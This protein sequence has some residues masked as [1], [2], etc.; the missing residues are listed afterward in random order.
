MRG[1]TG[2][3]RAFDFVF[4]VKAPSE[5][6]DL[7]DHLLADLSVDSAT[8]ADGRPAV[9]SIDVTRR[10]SGW[11]TRCTPDPPRRGELGD[12]IADVIQVINQRGV[13]SSP[14][15]VALHAAAIATDRGIVALMGSS[16]AGKS[17]LAAGAVLTGMGYVADEVTVI[18]SDGTAQPFHRP[19]GLRSGGALALGIDTPVHADGRFDRVYPWRPARASLAD[20]GPLVAV[21]IVDHVDG[22][23]GAWAPL[24]PA[25]A[26]IEMAAGAFGGDPDNDR[27][28]FHQ[29]AALVG[30][31]PAARL[32]FP[33]PDRGV[34][35]LRDFV[36]ACVQPSCG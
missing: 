35:L 14:D 6:V 27:A 20:G 11:T 15:L 4:D 12:V 8:P 18:G 16:G 36:R 23:D 21:C 1:R 2:T 34:K 10:R 33:D 32:T 31:I 7:F 29:L 30:A 9:E 28:W 26:L 13:R 3:F 22:C 24:R 19:I 25:E 17:T 5:L